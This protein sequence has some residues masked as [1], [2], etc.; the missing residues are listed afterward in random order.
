MA[1]A[2]CREAKQPIAG[3]HHTSIVICTH[4][5][6]TAATIPVGG[7]DPTMDPLPAPP[8]SLSNTGAGELEER[9]VGKDSQECQES[10]TNQNMERNFHDIK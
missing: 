9:M 3:I 10:H 4:R 8:E 1:V 5:S 2:G 7:T 6:I